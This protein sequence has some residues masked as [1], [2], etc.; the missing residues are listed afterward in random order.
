MG[1]PSAQVTEDQRDAAQLAKSKALDA[2]SQGNVFHSF[3]HLLVSFN[4]Q[5]IYFV[6]FISIFQAILIKP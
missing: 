2:L 3:F 5:I 4:F 6:I 1:N